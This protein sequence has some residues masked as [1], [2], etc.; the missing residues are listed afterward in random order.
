MRV[1]V[2]LG[3]GLRLELGLDRLTTVTV[4]VSVKLWLRHRD[5]DEL[6]KATMVID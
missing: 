2:C 6:L 3:L 1:G 5:F 4:K